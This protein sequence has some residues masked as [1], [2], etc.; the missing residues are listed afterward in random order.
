MP[1]T[2]EIPSGIELWRNPAVLVKSRMWGGRAGR[3]DVSPSSVAAAPPLEEVASLLVAL[4]PLD[5]GCID[6]GALQPELV[7]TATIKIADHEELT[8]V[9][10]DA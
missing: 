6:V 5:I 1:L 3:G 2:A 7:T 8:I 4:P 10:N 9:T